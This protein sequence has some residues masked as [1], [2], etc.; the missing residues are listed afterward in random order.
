[1]PL[2]FTTIHFDE[3][4]LLED[5]NSKLIIFIGV[6]DLVAQCRKLAKDLIDF[7]PFP[8]TGWLPSN[9]TL[10]RL[11]QRFQMPQVLNHNVEEAVVVTIVIGKLEAPILL[12]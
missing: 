4:L 12:V 10:E 3:H 6:Q 1:M 5:V 7:L 2:S 9:H 11:A 8:T